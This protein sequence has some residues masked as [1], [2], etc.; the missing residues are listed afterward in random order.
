MAAVD[1]VFGPGPVGAVG[2][3][4][5]AIVASGA[6][7]PDSLAAAGAAYKAHLPIV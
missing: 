6:N 1:A 3:K 7:F 4:R 5:T 2:A